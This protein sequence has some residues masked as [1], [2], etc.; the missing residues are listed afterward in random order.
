MN[1]KIPRTAFLISLTI[2][3]VGC[4]TQTVETKS[5]P[6]KQKVTKVIK[7][8]PKP[9]VKVVVAEPEPIKII[10]DP[11]IEKIQK[12]IPK[13]PTQES[14]VYFDFDSS[15]LSEEAKMI[16]K[17]HSEFLRENP[18]Y[19]VTLE[20][21]ADAR[22]D[23]SYNENLGSQRVVAIK[24]VLLSENIDENQ[25]NLV[26]YGE[27]KPAVEGD[28]ISAWRSNRRAI[29]IYNHQTEKQNQNAKA[30]ASPDRLMVLG[31]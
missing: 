26:S 3:V 23:E 21:H 31:E 19:S 13:P 7:V 11:V 8:E 5:E 17:K 22:G 12:V 15:Q 28:S 18:E 9:S 29:F 27:S 30:N 2:F 20:G 24:A 6:K 1:L 16:V 4:A 10:P 14:T 25:I